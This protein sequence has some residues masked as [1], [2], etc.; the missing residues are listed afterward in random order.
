[1]SSLAYRRGS[2]AA[3]LLLAVLM[4]V[5]QPVSADI[6]IELEGV[7]GDLRRNVLALLSLERYQDRDRLQ[8]DAV[9]RLYNRID[10]EVRSALRPYGYYEPIISSSISGPDKD[11]HWHVKITIEPGTPVLIARVSIRI[12]GPGAEDAVFKRLTADPPLRSGQRLS[13]A[14]Y[15]QYKGSLERAA[16]T[17][18]YLD[19]RMLRSE[20]QVDRDAYLATIQ[21]QLDTG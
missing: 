1:M 4:S 20:M 6:R 12:D 16:A 19:A 18:G 3:W 8:P 5:L 2:P 11:R 9:Q 21:L 10:D 7:D 17:Y 15:D 13:H 14:I